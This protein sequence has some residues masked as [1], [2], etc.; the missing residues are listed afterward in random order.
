MVGSSEESGKGMKGSGSIGLL[1]AACLGTALCLLATACGFQLGN[2]D[3]S[4]GRENEGP[5]AVSSRDEAESATVKIETSGVQTDPQCGTPEQVEGGGT[6]F[7]M[8][9]SG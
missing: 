5:A 4:Q 2:S 3:S 9:P 6:G 8:D 7:V 1:R